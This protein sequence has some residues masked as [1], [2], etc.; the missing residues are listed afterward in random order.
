MHMIRAIIVLLSVLMLP[1]MA[2][3][4]SEGFS[5]SGDGKVVPM[6]KKGPRPKDTSYVEDNV[7]CYYKDKDGVLTFEFAEPEGKALLTVTRLEDGDYATASFM[8]YRTYSFTVGTAPGTYR[9][10]ITTSR[11]QYQGWLTIE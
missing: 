2:F 4:Q 7:T 6:P 11:D 5:Q 1:L 3:A 8:T 9:L 10:D